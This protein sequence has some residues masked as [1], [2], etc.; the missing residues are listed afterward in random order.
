[1]QGSI[2]LSGLIFYIGFWVLGLYFGLVLNDWSQ[3]LATLG[4]GLVFDP[5]PQNI[6]WNQRSRWQRA[7]PIIHLGVMAGILGWLIS[8]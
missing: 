2:Q 3:A 6:S 7:V 4:I 5:F 1:M 8:H